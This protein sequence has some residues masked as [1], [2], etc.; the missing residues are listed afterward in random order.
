MI[1]GKSERKHCF[2]CRFVGGTTWRGQSS[3]CQWR[4]CQRSLRG[5]YCNF[6]KLSN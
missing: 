3:A 4:F 2:A 1:C 5:Q 6:A